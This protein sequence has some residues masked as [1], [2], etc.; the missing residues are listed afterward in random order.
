[1]K[2]KILVLALIGFLG[3]YMAPT[4]L[5][6]SQGKTHR[7]YPE[8]KQSTASDIEIVKKASLPG[9]GKPVESGKPPK[10]SENAATGILGQTVAGNR[11]AVVIGISDYPG[12][13]SDL[14]YTDDDALATRNV[15]VSQYGFDDANIYLLTDGETAAENLSI[16]DGNPS[17]DNIQN[18]VID[19]KYNRELTSNDEVVFFF[20]GHGAKGRAND[21]DAE[22]IDESI[23]SYY[24]ETNFAY[25][26]DGNLK[27]WFSDFPTQRIVFIFDSCVSGGMTD[28]AGVGRIVNMAT[29]ETGF[30]TAVESVYGGIGAGE[31][32]YHFVIK[33][34]D[35]GLADI[36]GTPGVITI[37]EAFD[38]TKAN[39]GYDHPTISDK[40]TY[41]LAL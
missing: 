9:K 19:L 6:N 29:Q 35:E 39:I 30:D 7:T 25:I 8:F 10:A 28:L 31:F 2:N 4:L 38:Y 34:M 16:V 26:W 21:G 14:N 41:D 36:T 22:K 37:E 17:Y 23:V 3:L 40:F 5:A 20:S 1:M 15:L 12:S 18:A 11:Y 13:S 32:T 27:N 33:G 24:D